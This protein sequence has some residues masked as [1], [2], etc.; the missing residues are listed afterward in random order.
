MPI[1]TSLSHAINGN[2]N[3]LDNSTGTGEGTSFSLIGG[4]RCTIEAKGTTSSGSGAASINIEV[5]NNGTT[6]QTAGTIGLTLG[7]TQTSDG[8]A[9][10]APWL[11]IRANVT[12]ISGTDAKVSVIISA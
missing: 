2:L 4:G 10:D 6:W 3:I 1:W 7:T 9:M 11:Y 8:F 12:S 5:S